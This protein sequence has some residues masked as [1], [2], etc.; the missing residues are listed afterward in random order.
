VAEYLASDD[1]QPEI[2]AMLG[3]WIE[4]GRPAVLVALD[5]EPPF[6]QVYPEDELLETFPDVPVVPLGPIEDLGP[7]T[8]LVVVIDEESETAYLIPNPR[9]SN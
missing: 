8:L 7:R 9:A 1:L 2:A 5:W 4:P 6:A 3:R